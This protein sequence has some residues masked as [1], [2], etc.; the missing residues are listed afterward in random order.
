MIKLM[1]KGR[2][3]IAPEVFN[4]S[5]PDTGNMEVLHLFGSPEQKEKY[6]QPLLEG[7]IRSCFAMTEPAVASSDASS[8]SSTIIKDP[9]NP[10]FYIVNGRKWWISGAGDPRCE[11]AIFMGKTPLPQ[12]AQSQ[13]NNISAHSSHSMILVPFSSPGIK[14]VRPLTVFGY[15]DAPSGHLELIFEN[16]RV[17]A[18]NLILKEGSGFHIAQGRLGPGRIHHCMRLVGMAQRA[19]ELMCQRVWQREIGMGN[20]RGFLAE[21]GGIE[22]EIGKARSRVEM[23]R[24]MVL[25]AAKS[26]DERGA[27][28]AMK[29]IAM[30]KATV[31]RLVGK[32][33]DQAIQVFILN[34]KQFFIQI[35]FH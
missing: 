13:Q 28:S 11:F 29:E 19:F 15:D 16:V 6:L 8:I 33:V 3:S 32:V 18:S 17:P 34:F 23:A 14:K 1:L 9:L 24:I 25:Y 10:N 4:C 30:I 5:A 22:K 7:K 26:M 27:R 12:T 2:S 20:A 21:V 35:I 31:P